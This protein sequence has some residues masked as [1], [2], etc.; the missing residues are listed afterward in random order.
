MRLLNLADV[1]SKIVHHC[2]PDPAAMPIPGV[3]R[4]KAINT[5]LCTL[6][7][8]RAYCCSKDSVLLHTM[9]SL[10]MHVILRAAR[11]SILLLAACSDMM[12]PLTNKHAGN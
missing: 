7:L 4:P 5:L 9:V 12:L 11:T 3:Q 1:P 6:A 8:L 10:A 2:P